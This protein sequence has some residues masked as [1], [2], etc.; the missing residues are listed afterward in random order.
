MSAA[1]PSSEPLQAVGNIQFC[2]NC[3]NK[4]Y[5][6]IHPTTGA[7]ILYCRA[8]A[9]TKTDIT[10][11]TCVLSTNVR[12]Q[13]VNIHSLVNKYTKYDPTLPH[14]YLLC[15]NQDC[16]TNTGKDAPHITD[17]AIIR[18]NYEQMK[19]IYICTECDHVWEPRG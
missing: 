4:Y 10:N 1:A 7:L 6:A 5:H 15:P 18:Y 9:H 2:E 3:D 14:T 12:S 8:C 19:F 16:S 11:T 17:A 13:A